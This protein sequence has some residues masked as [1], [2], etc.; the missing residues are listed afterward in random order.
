LSSCNKFLIHN[1]SH[2]PL[3]IPLYFASALDLVTTP[4]FLLCHVTR[5]P[6]TNVKYLAVECLSSIEPA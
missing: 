6:P 5:F 2:T 1:S 4:C 3:V